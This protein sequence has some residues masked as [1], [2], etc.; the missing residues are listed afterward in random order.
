MGWMNVR[1]NAE[2]QL[3]AQD[4]LRQARSHS[5][6]PSKALAS[7]HVNV[8]IFDNYLINPSSLSKDERYISSSSLEDSAIAF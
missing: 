8:N 7:N 3:E 1:V 5:H 4:G 2:T 6:P